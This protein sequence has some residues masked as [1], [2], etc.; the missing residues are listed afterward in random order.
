MSRSLKSVLSSATPTPARL[1]GLSVRLAGFMVGRT[2]SVLVDAKTIA[3]GIITGVLTDSGMPQL[4]MGGRK[5]DPN[6]V[7]TV[8][9]TPLN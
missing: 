6:Q 8:T 7:L 5:Y 3:H 2:V 4:V 1:D 9:P